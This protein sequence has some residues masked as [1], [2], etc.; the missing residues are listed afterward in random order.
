MNL[1]ISFRIILFEKLYRANFY[2]GKIFTMYYFNDLLTMS[3]IFTFEVNSVQNYMVIIH[4]VLTFIKKH[5]TGYFKKMW[6]E[7]IFRDKFSEIK[8]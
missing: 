1:K 6:S 7:A 8:L 5:K 3:V 2:Q 4:Q